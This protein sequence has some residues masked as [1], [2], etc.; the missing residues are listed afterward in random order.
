[1][2]ELP[3]D[4]PVCYESFRS[5]DDDE[6]LVGHRLPT[7][8]HYACAACLSDLLD[9]GEICCPTCFEMNA[10]GDSVGALP[11]IELA[12]DGSATD[13]SDLPSEASDDGGGAADDQLAE[14]KARLASGETLSPAEVGRSAVR[15][16][17]TIPPPRPRND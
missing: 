1:M 10:V 9:D 11:V 6:N 4:C 15:R 13:A 16:I 12:D 3:T 2:D 14:L 8:G 5:A 17:R 7:C